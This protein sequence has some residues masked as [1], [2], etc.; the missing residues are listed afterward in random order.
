M[1]GFALLLF[2]APAKFHR[3]ARCLAA[4]PVVWRGAGSAANL[5]AETCAIPHGCSDTVSSRCR[6]AVIAACWRRRE[7]R[8]LSPVIL[9]FAQ[10]LFRLTRI[11]R[12]HRWGDGRTHE[13]LTSE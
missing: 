3:A 10:Q 6:W 13:Q 9:V 5:A 4:I 11:S 1:W 7:G 2:D 12:V 8:S